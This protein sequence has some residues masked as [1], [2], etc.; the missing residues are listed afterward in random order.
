MTE[1]DRSFWSQ[2]SGNIIIG[3]IG[4]VG[5][6]VAA[7]VPVVL[8]RSATPASETRAGNKTTETSPAASIPAPVKDN[9]PQVLRDLEQIQGVWEVVYRQMPDPPQAQTTVP[10]ETSTAQGIPLPYKA[11][12][13][14]PRQR[15][16]SPQNAR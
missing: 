14:D 13:G 3:V 10:A 15:S 9:R 1:N 8:N 2:H 5:A 7:V 4:A 11:F 12:W 6:I 16:D